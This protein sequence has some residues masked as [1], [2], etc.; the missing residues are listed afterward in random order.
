MKRPTQWRPPS[1][2]PPTEVRRCFDAERRKREPWRNWYKLAV[3]QRARMVQLQR[4]PLC[5]R[6]LAQGIVEAA[7]VV[8]HHKAHK[9]DW[10]LFISSAN[11]ESV[12][13]RCHDS[14]IQSEEKSS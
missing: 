5:E 8:N 9:G 10:S 2:P 1:A 14:V 13:K 7:T 4:Q 12:C 6:C 11:H 3:W